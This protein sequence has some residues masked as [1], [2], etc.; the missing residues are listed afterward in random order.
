MG[1]HFIP[2]AVYTEGARVTHS[3]DQSIPDD[4]AF[5]T[6]AFDTERWDTDNIHDN[7]ANNSR[8]TCKTAGK[9][10]VVFHGY[11]E[12]GLIGRRQFRITKNGVEVHP[13][14]E[15]GLEPGGYFFMPVSCIIDLAVNDYVEASV[16]Q[17]SGGAL[18]LVKSNFV[19]P[20][21]MMQRIG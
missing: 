14:G 20:E 15:A 10:L 11:M 21:F 2:A 8:L 6:V 4:G 13:A 12:H 5:H 16:Y 3:V 1:F 18:D 19:S 9:Y 7:V 17:T